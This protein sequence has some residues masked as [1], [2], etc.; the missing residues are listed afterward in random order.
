[1]LDPQNSGDLSVQR[2]ARMSP[3]RLEVILR[4]F[5]LPLE[6]LR[7]WFECLSMRLDLF[8]ASCGRGLRPV[9]AK[10]LDAMAG[11]SDVQIPA[12]RLHQR[13]ID[14]RPR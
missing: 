6:R 14:R 12:V 2:L 3:H 1:M 11:R 10:Y 7:E 9:H 4:I 5:E 8:Q 13:S